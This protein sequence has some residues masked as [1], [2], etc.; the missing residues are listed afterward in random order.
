MVW[1]SA[2]PHPVEDGPY[3]W[4]LEYGQLIMR[5]GNATI[6]GSYGRNVSMLNAPTSFELEMISGKRC[7]AKIYDKNRQEI[8]VSSIFNMQLKTDFFNHYEL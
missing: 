8:W 6:V 3:T 4:T 1:R 2:R 5:S 7:V